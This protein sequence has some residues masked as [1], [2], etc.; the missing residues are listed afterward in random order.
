MSANHDALVH[1]FEAYVAEN[2]KFEVK[3]VKASAARAR[4]ALG[5]I[6][7]LCKERRKEIQD[8]KNA[9]K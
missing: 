9:A 5:E 1:Q 3:G 6:A 7:K 8:A 4:K 2:E